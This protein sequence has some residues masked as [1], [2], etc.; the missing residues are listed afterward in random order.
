MGFNK[1]YV[2][3]VKELKKTLLEKGSNWFYKIYVTSPDALIGPSESIEF[4]E[5]FQK[6]NKINKTDFSDIIINS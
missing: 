6:N 3:E 2:P 1:R 5:E 4:I